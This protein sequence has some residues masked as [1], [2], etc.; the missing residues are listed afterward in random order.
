MEITRMFALTAKPIAVAAALAAT[1]L[2]LTAAASPAHAATYEL[3]QCTTARPSTPGWAISYSGSWVAHGDECA[4]G[5]GLRAWFDSSASHKEGDNIVWRFTAPAN[6]TVGSVIAESRTFRAGAPNPGGFGDSVA[7]ARSGN[8]EVIE[9]CVQMYGCGIKSGPGSWSPA[10]GSTQVE[11]GVLCTGANGCPA[12]SVYTT[13]RGIHVRLNDDAA[14]QLTGLSGS[15]TSTST[16][17]R[18]RTLSFSATDVGGGVYRRR[19]VVDDAA[20][21]PATVDANGGACAA[22]F[23]NRVPCKLSASESFSFDTAALSD[24]RHDVSMRVTDATDDNAIQSSSWSILVDNQPPVIAAPVLTGIAREGDTLTCAAGVD[25]Q[26][27][28]LSFRWLRAAP[29]GSGATEIPGATNAAY[30]IVA[31][32]IAGKLICRVS[33]TDAGG[34][35]SRETTITQ[36]PFD[37][38]RTVAPYCSGRPTGAKDECGDLDGDGTVNRL[39]GDIDGDGIP[40]ADD[41]NPYDASKPATAPG[42]SSTTTSTVVES[43]TTHTSSVTAAPVAAAQGTTDAGAVRFLLGRETATFVGRQARWLRSSFVLRGRLTSAGG[44]ALAGV[45]LHIT[46]TVRGVT[47]ALGE[48]TSTTD[49]AWAFRVPRGPSRTITVTAGDGLNAATMTIQQRVTA[50]VT[51]RAVTRKVARGGR[52]VFRG[53]LHGGFVNTRE[54]LVEFQVHYRGA[55][56]TISTLRTDRKG[57]FSVRYRFGSAAYGR[58]TFRARTRPP[59][60]YPFGVGISRGRAAT[61]KVG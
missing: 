46:Q 21:A 25:G 56:R 54:K 35:S 5:V 53:A 52:V 17:A 23:T 50:H 2:T 55:W 16:T 58:Y 27:P 45:K 8:G 28:Q 4:S 6:T 40:N 24:G 41:S 9:S 12:D 42:S 49:G 36:A 61:V 31:G 7:L 48:A 43:T 32:D 3:E 38:G 13:V 26:S 15:L 18:V 60:G 33:A 19:L 59:D 37:Q 1:G 14:P 39:D 57:R 10:A 44:K 51:F 20:L 22:P 30:T 34:T 47:V 29:A 11:F